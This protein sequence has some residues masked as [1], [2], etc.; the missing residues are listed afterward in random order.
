MCHSLKCILPKAELGFLPHILHST[1][2]CFISCAHAK[3]NCLVGYTVLDPPRISHQRLCHHLPS[4]SPSWFVLC[5]KC[6]CQ[7]VALTVVPVIRE[8]SLSCVWWLPLKPQHTQKEDSEF[9]ASWD[10]RVRLLL[11][12]SLEGER[13]MWGCSW[14]FALEYLEVESVFQWSLSVML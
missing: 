14:S 7:R 8:E 9:E 3:Q 1:S 10:Y 12:G 2:V 5:S 13:R 6:A 4:Q 11:K